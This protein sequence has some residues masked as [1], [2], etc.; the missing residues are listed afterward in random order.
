MGWGRT[1]ARSLA[2]AAARAA[3]TNDA[4]LPGSAAPPVGAQRV[5]SVPQSTR[6]PRAARSTLRSCDTRPSAHRTGKGVNPSNEAGAHR[7]SQAKSRLRPR[8]GPCCAGPSAPQPKGRA[9]DARCTRWLAPDAC[10]QSRN[11]SHNSKKCLGTR[12]PGSNF[13]TGTGRARPPRLPKHRATRCRAPRAS[14]CPLDTLGA[15]EAGRARCG[16]PPSLAPLGARARPVCHEY[17]G[18]DSLGRARCSHAT[19]SGR[20]ARNSAAPVSAFSHALLHAWSTTCR[21]H[22]K[23]PCVPR[24]VRVCV[25]VC[26]CV[27]ACA[28]VRVCARACV[29]VCVC[30]CV[31]L[32]VRVCV[33]VCVS[34][35]PH[36]TLL[37]STPTRPFSTPPLQHSTLLHP[38]STLLYTLPL[39]HSTLYSAPTPLYP[40]LPLQHSSLLTQP[41]LHPTLLHPST[42]TH[43]DTHLTAVRCFHP[44]LLHCYTAALSLCTLC[45]SCP[46]ARYRPAGQ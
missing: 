4:A 30:V 18:A 42:H 28:C 20:T 39:L 31:C 5:H 25:C 9:A 44:A 45:P 21:P 46:P 22:R 37:Y 19:G 2:R 24:V 38:Y 43:Y 12:A 16:S 14:C 40:T 10:E 33:C 41:Q 32:C 27:C 3:G 6:W 8:G 29:C 35:H 7:P 36:S 23:R 34:P 26:V 1:R 17:A 13:S 11:H 15:P